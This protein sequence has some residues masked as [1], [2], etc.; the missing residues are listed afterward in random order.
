MQ[1]SFGSTYNDILHTAFLAIPVGIPTSPHQSPPFNTVESLYQRLLPQ[2]R[3]MNKYV[4]PYVS[5]L[6]LDSHY[7][8]FTAIK[9]LEGDTVVPSELIA[10]G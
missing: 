7:M 6:N 4:Q 1:Y 2:T 5:E 3:P 8:Y 9:G 10:T